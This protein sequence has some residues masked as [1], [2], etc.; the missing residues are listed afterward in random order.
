[1]EVMMPIQM[2]PDQYV[3][4]GNIN[5]RYWAAGDK[6]TPVV[7]VHGLGG[8]IENWILNMEPLAQRHRVYAPD[9]KG[10][11][12]TDKTPVLQ[13]LDELVRFIKDFMEVQRIAKASLIG[14]SLGGGLVLQFA[15]NF[16]DKVDKLVLVDNAGMGKGVI[17]D[18]KILSLPVIGELLYRPSLKATANLLRK[19]VFDPSLVTNEVVEMTYKLAILPGATKALL[20]AL[21]AGIGVRGQRANLTRPLLADAAKI[22]APTL[23]FWGQQDKI[24]PV[25]HGHI[26][27][28]TIPHSR[29]QVYDR[30]GHMPQVERPDEFNSLVLEFLAA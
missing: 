9:L 2:P 29:L 5:T 19:I 20:A 14:N 28:K 25:A 3:K 6:G 27:E 10:F 4:V 18:F 11:G 23:I 22:A 26:A 1:M 7:L 30:C 15:I 17:T 21:R 13:D 24:I 12:R 16:P 8:S